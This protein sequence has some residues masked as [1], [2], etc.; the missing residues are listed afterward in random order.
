MTTPK[1]LKTFTQ[2]NSNLKNSSSNKNNVLGSNEALGYHVKNEGCFRYMVCSMVR[3]GLEQQLGISS[4][5]SPHTGDIYDP[6]NIQE[7][8]VENIHS[9]HRIGN[10]NGNSFSGTTMS[11]LDTYNNTEDSDEPDNSDILLDTEHE[12]EDDDD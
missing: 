12:N 1:F 10:Q 9:S 7:N 6:N 3:F 4:Q 5:L 8:N 11:N 2:S